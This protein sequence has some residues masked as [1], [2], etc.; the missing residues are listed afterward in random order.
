MIP[1]SKPAVVV[2]FLM[3]VVFSCGTD[4]GTLIDLVPDNDPVA[5][6]TPGS[7]TCKVDGTDFSA[8]GVLATGTLTFT[9]DFY[10]M[11]I[12][13]VDFFGQD[14]VALALAMSGTD[15]ANLMENEAFTGEGDIVNSNLG[16]GEINIHRRPTIDDKASSLETEIAN[17]TITKLDRD[18]ELFSGTF[19]FEGL[20]PDTNTRIV[21]TEGVFT[22][23]EYN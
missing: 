2:A 4:E 13:G 7:V 8:S 5:P 3:L 9:G 21:V 23:I 14:T 11:A 17:I 1:F 16:A 22:D 12:A 6:G 15:F 19:S 10:A 18:N 20:D